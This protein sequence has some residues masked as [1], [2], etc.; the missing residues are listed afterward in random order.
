MKWEHD[1]KEEMETNM[2]LRDL[3]SRSDIQ[4][5][6]NMRD[7]FFGGRTNATKLYYSVKHGEQIK[8]VDFT[9]LYPWTNKYARYPVGHV[10]EIITDGF[11]PMSQYFGFAHVNILP[12]RQLY[13]PVLPYR[14][15]GKLKFP[16]CRTCA[17]TENQEVCV[18]RD[19]ERSI[20][21]TWC[22]PEIEKAIEC[23][24]T[25][26]K[27]YEVYHWERSAQYDP[28]NRQDG[29]FSAFID[30]FLKIKQESSGW[31]SWCT[32][33]EDKTRYVHEY[34]RHEGVQLDPSSIEKNPGKRA[35]AKLMLNRYV[36]I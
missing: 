35:L 19:D 5:R 17:D 7:A 28:S 24:Y 6:L 16:L 34:E 2:V 12:P 30:T 3:V 31:P 9:S 1:F 21:G 20:T 26:K 33:E 29:L 36:P 22:T 14:S 25:I 18:C 32:S 23:G 10:T 11:Q 4:P 8:Y 27:V 15:G 13:H